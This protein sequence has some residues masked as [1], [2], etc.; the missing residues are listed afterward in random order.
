MEDERALVRERVHHQLVQ[1]PR[2]LA[3]A[4]HEQERPLGR[5]VEASPTF[6]TWGCPRAG[7][8]RTPRHP[9]LRAG[10][11]GDREG[12]KD[13]ASERQGQTVGQAEMRVGFHDRRRNAAAGSCEHHRPCDVATAAENDIGPT[14]FEDSATR[15]RSLA[16][17]QERPQQRHARLPRKPGDLER[18]ELVAGFRN[19]LR[20]G[21]TGRPGERHERAARSQ[22]F[23]HRERRQHVAAGSPGCDQAP[24]RVSLG[25]RHLR[26]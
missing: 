12:E 14:A 4:V 10:P 9:V 6:V 19:E 24:R 13:A 15:E 17:N 26:C 23:R 25:H 20:F 21:A 5:Q 11:A 22:R 7:R 2:P 18:V 3:P 1:R 16:R 8:N